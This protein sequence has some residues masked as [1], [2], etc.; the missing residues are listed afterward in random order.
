[1]IPLRTLCNDLT[2]SCVPLQ[3]TAIGGIRVHSGPAWSAL[4]K[5]FTFCLKAKRLLFLFSHLPSFF[6]YEFM[7]AYMHVSMSC[8]MCSG[9]RTTCRRW[10]ILSIMWSLGIKLRSSALVT[11][12]SLPELLC[13]P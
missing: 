13:G 7:Y 6:G 2:V 9:Q 11:S 4:E 8:G 12:T 1:M 5:H 10:S 3:V